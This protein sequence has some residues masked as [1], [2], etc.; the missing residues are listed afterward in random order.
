MIYANE[1]MQKQTKQF[2]HI[3]YNNV[4]IDLRMRLVSE[5]FSIK[6]CKF[7][8]TPWIKYGAILCENPIHV[9]SSNSIWYT[10]YDFESIFCLFVCV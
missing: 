9:T 4:F 6:N 5:L 8:A 1:F 10:V 3:L 2:S 7:R